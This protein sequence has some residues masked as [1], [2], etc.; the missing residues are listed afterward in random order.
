MPAWNNRNPQTSRAPHN[1]RLQDSHT[2]THPYHKREQ[3][4]PC[5]NNAPSTQFVSRNH[6]KKHRLS[7]RAKR[8]ICFPAVPLQRL[9]GLRYAV[10][11]EAVGP[12]PRAF[13]HNTNGQ[14]NIRTNAAITASPFAR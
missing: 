11:A 1:H 6:S 2:W 4:T 9:R 5:N 10:Y 3:T 14:A 7:F 13:I 8:G 12:E